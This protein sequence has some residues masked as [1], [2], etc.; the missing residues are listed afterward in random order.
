[1]VASWFEALAPLVLGVVP[2]LGVGVG[3]GVTVGVGVTWTVKELV[4]FPTLKVM[5]WGLA[6]LKVTVVRFVVGRR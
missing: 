4:R 5:T 3:E 1:M 2:A 6:W